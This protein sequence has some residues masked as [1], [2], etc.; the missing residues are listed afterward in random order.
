[1][2]NSQAGRQLKEAKPGMAAWDGFVNNGSLLCRFVMGWLQHQ[3]E[4]TFLN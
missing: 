1:M 4:F 3:V 2:K